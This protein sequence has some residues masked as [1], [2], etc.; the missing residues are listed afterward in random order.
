MDLVSVNPIFDLYNQEWPIYSW[1]TPLPPAKFVHEEKGRS[2]VAFNSLV[3]KGAIVS[4]GTV[5]RS[6][7]SPLVRVSSSALVEDSVLFDEV[8]VGR[9][10]IVKRAILDKLVEIP[11]GYELGVNHERDRERFTVSDDGVVVIGKKD[12]LD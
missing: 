3:S 2:G 11:A 7:L 5:R 1:Q 6:I 12:V 9:G 10:A 8:S 4:G